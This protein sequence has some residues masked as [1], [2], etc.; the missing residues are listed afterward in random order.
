MSPWLLMAIMVVAFAAA[1]TLAWPAIRRLPPPP[2]SSAHQLEVYRDQLAEIAR[3]EARGLL[4]AA[5][6]A[7]MRT[8]V[9]RRILRIAEEPPP[10]GEAPGGRAVAAAV[11]LAVPLLATGL[12]LAVGSPTLPD[13]PLAARSADPGGEDLPDIGAMVARLEQRLQ[14]D[15]DDA[16]GWLMLGRS[17]SVLDEYGLAAIAF[18]RALELRPDD[19]EA[20]GGLAESLIAQAGGLV[21]GEPRDL[22]ERLE[23]RVPGDPRAGYYLGLAAAQAGDR[24]AASG[25]WRRLL[26]TAPRD[27]PWR[28]SVVAAI[29]EAGASLGVDVAA[30]I[31]DQPAAESDPRAAEAA[32]IAALP[33]E[34]QQA[35]I[36]DMVD[37]L[38]ARLEADGGTVEE[39]S[40]LAQAR[41]VLGDRAAAAAA[42]DRALAEKPDDPR[43][44]KGKARVLLGEATEPSGLPVVPRE[45]ATLLERA[46]A[47]DADDPEIDWLLGIHALQQGAPGEAR[48]RWQRVLARLGPSD[49]GRAAVESQLDRLT[50]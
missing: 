8:E 15:P 32:R 1:A 24:V 34:Q 12:Y 16:D 26:A 38:A 5:E 6:A 2:R 27:A 44:L 3:E 48:E 18:R 39:W 25:H 4:G 36:R 17:R 30:I 31:D 14:A 7:A 28:A 47:L 43:A 37:G 10:P 50:P 22:L 9:E 29:R 11:A 23:Q 13:R 46:A 35:R 41:L 33:P 21:G 45:A 40:R 20:L 19:P 49:P 42:W